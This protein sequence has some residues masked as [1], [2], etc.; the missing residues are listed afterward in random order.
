MQ[1]VITSH[2]HTFFSLDNTHIALDFNYI[3]VIVQH[4]SL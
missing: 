4:D 1:A 3:K 2:T